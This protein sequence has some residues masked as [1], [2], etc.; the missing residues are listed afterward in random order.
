[1]MQ[2]LIKIFYFYFMYSSLKGRGSQHLILRPATQVPP[3]NMLE[4]HILDHP[5]DLLNWDLQGWSSKI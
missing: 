1:M 3:K 2:V 5:P 4:M